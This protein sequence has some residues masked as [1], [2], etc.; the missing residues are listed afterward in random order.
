MSYLKICLAFYNLGNSKIVIEFVNPNFFWS[1]LYGVGKTHNGRY[2]NEST[3]HYDGIHYFGPRGSWDYTN[4]LSNA[5]MKAIS[6]NQ[7]QRNPSPFN[8]Q[9]KPVI[10]TGI[11]SIN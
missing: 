4:S 2:L 3:G 7:D 8:V 6:N 11:F 5:I 1:T 9:P 10:L